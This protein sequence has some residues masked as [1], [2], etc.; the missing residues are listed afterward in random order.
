[1]PGFLIFD[2]MQHINEPVSAWQISITEMVRPD[3]SYEGRIIFNTHQFQ[4]IQELAKYFRKPD[5]YPVAKSLNYNVPEPPAEKWN[6]RMIGRITFM[7]TDY[8][9]SRLLEFDSVDD[10]VRFLEDHPPL[11]KVVEYVPR[12]K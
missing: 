11:A 8:M 2:L 1:M 10:F 6:P 4:T 9:M 12:T 7:Y 5:S 3:F